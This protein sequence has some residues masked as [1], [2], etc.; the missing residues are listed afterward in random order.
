MKYTR[1]TALGDAG[2]FYFAYQIAKVLKWPC[3]LFDIDIGVDA[4]VETM[5]GDESTGKFVAFQIK[6]S[7]VEHKFRRYVTADQLSYWKSL[8]V[9]VFAVLV[10]MR[11]GK[12]YLHLIDR[13]K[14]YPLTKKGRRRIDFDEI[15]EL[16]TPASG[17]T[18]KDASD[19]VA[20]SEIARYLRKV[21][22]GAERIRLALEGFEAYPDPEKAIELIRERGALRGE[23][24]KARALAKSYRV[25]VVQCDQAGEELAGSLRLLHDYV[26]EKE[27]RRIWDDRGKGDGDIGRFLD[28]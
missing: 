18:I 13:D 11:T 26:V 2:E 17:A 27:L 20:L 19:K 5:V 8:D 3:R 10:D 28:E 23:L 25:G 12:M 1:K 22:A 15:S 24:S 16:F 9:P 14:K 6:A 4:Q 21:T 7:G